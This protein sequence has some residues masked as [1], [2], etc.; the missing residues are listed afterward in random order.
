MIDDER[1]E[2]ARKL[3]HEADYW[4]SSGP[5]DTCLDYTASTVCSVLECIGMRDGYVS[6]HSMLDRLA[7]LIDRPICRDNG[8]HYYF[9]CSRCRIC[10]DVIEPN[11]CPICGAEVVE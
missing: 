3:R 4:A 7:D 5:T 6:I 2:A 8:E 9:T 10:S 1:R 11:Y